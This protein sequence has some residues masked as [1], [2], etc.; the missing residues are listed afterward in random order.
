MGCLSLGTWKRKKNE[1]RSVDGARVSKLPTQQK[2]VACIRANIWSVKKWIGSVC[3]KSEW[4]KF[5]IIKFLF[6]SRQIVHFSS[7]VILFLSF[8]SFISRRRREHTKG[9]KRNPVAV[10][11]GKKNRKEVNGGPEALLSSV[12]IRWTGSSKSPLFPLSP[13]E[14][15]RKWAKRD[16]GNDKNL[17]ILPSLLS[18]AQMWKEKK[19][20]M[21]FIIFLPFPFPFSSSLYTIYVRLTIYIHIYIYRTN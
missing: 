7:I 10:V 9:K 14:L 6:P 18:Y 20:D 1:Y 19:K 12:N 5:L 11:Q 4:I 17:Y 21:K 2:S 13:A 16:K 3:N 8:L 15:D